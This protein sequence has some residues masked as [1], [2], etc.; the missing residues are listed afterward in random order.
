MTWVIGLGLLW[1]GVTI[2]PSSHIVVSL[3]A[4]VARTWF[5]V[6]FY[7]LVSEW[8]RHDVKA[9]HRFIAFLVMPLTVVIAYT[10]IR[11]GQYG[12]SKASGHWVMKPFLRTTLPYGAVLAML[13]LQPLR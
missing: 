4:W 13:L 6:A 1:M 10:M 5:V 7:V 8:F 12:F 2:I 11:H 3:K 9:K